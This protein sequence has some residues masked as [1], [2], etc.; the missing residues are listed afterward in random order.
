MAHGSWLKAHAHG[1]RIMAHASKLVAQGSWPRKIWRGVPQGPGPA[2]HVFLAMS[3]EPCGM[4]H[5]PRIIIHRRILY[6]P[7]PNCWNVF[8]KVWKLQV[9]KHIN[10]NNFKS[11]AVLN[12]WDVKTRKLPNASILKRQDVNVSKSSI[13][14]IP[15]CHNVKFASFNCLINFH[16]LLN[17]WI[18]RLFVI[19]IR[20]WLTEKQLIIIGCK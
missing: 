16:Y 15:K 8:L 10:S 6:F 20:R 1:S 13:F 17:W 11:F 18:V 2:R 5:E 14:E 9:V 4:R 3:H 19:S 7:N 12:L